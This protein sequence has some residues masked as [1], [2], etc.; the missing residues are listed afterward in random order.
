MPVGEWR[1][2]RSQVSGEISRDLLL[3][4]CYRHLN[5]WFLEFQLRLVVVIN[6]FA[7][8]KVPSQ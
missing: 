3:R 8:E 5:V 2:G 6:D 1:D 7:T 4:T